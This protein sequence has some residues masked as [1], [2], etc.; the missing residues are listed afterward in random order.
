MMTAL[1]G[2][3]AL[4]ISLF[5][6]FLF[7]GFCLYLLGTN[8]SLQLKKG[9]S[10]VIQCRSIYLVVILLGINVA[11]WMSSGLLATLIYYVLN[12]IKPRLFLVL[13]FNVTALLAFIMGTGLGTF[14]TIGMVFLTLSVPLGI[15]KEV[16]VGCLVSG[17]FVAD[18]VSFSSALTQLNLKVNHL[19]YKIFIKSAIKTMGPG[20]IVASV[21][22][23]LIPIQADLDPSRLKV[24]QDQ[25]AHTFVIKASLLLIPL[26]F[27]LMSLRALPSYLSLSILILTNIG[28][29][30]LLQGTRLSQVMTYILRG[31]DNPQ[32]NLFKGGGILPMLEV[33]FI[34]M[35][36]VF[37]TGQIMALKLFD[38][39]FKWI[40]K[41]SK[42]PSHLVLNTGLISIFLTA[43][44]C[45]QTVGILL[46]AERLQD[47]YRD[48][49]L[50]KSL[51]ARTISDTGVIT[52]PLQ[53]W[54]VNALII[55]SLTGISAIDYAPYAFFCWLMPVITYLSTRIRKAS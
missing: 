1:A 54:N 13:A 53:F 35:V 26:A 52:A 11:L 47:K 44:T 41:K 42:T 37:V 5:W 48:L 55:L 20:L 2:S 49:A 34:V 3:L 8:K 18:K 45:D 14:S 31:Y 15:N 36:A 46:P 33:V 29:S 27:I 19:D 23:L 12:Y 40:I 28:L 9:L 38:P 17:A 50:D 30:L 43:I 25:L 22:Y 21:L 4:D 7:I 16:M 24:L 10:H 32:L 6:G 51:L 39:L